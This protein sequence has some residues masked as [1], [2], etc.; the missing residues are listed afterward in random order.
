MIE[1][2]EVQK[3]ITKNNPNPVEKKQLKD[4]VKKVNKM[5]DKDRFVDKNN[6]IIKQKSEKGLWKTLKTNYKSNNDIPNILIYNNEIFNGP[7]HIA[8]TFNNAFL[9][10][11][12]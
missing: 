11:K 10:K 2:L 8:N 12:N 3:I 1:E 6:F 5:K 7:N 9:E 4:L